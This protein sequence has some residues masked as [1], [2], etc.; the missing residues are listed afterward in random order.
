MS[1]KEN[2]S[3][4]ENSSVTQEAQTQ[5]QASDDEYEY[6]EV[7]EEETQT[8]SPEPELA[9]I[10]LIT[11]IK[12]RTDFES[13]EAFD[14]YY[15]EHKSELNKLTTHKLNKMF[16]IPGYRI[17]KIRGVLS[18]KNIPESRVTSVMRI[19]MLE[20]TVN[21]MK[22]KINTCIKTI[23]GVLDVLNH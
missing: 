2:V 1:E 10:P 7:D 23:N 5:Q 13:A 17:T 21:D 11:P 15:Q 16:E 14:A 12:E 4:V 22:D 9:H 18:L 8:P 19:N 20:K 6:V 3:K